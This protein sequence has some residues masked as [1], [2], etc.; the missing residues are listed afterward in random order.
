MSN[1][2]NICFIGFKIRASANSLSNPILTCHYLL[3]RKGIILV[4]LTQ[5]MARHA[6][7]QMVFATILLK[8]TSSNHGLSQNQSILNR[9]TI[10]RKQIKKK[11]RLSKRSQY[12][13][14][15]SHKLLIRKKI[16]KYQQ[17]QTCQTLL[18]QL[19]KLRMMIR[20]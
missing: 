4:V 17:S 15:Q 6:K 18:L 5:D 11:L 19:K 3:S 9:M 10:K 8:M 2:K 13:L 16:K 20:K 1:L 12:P 7:S 14:N